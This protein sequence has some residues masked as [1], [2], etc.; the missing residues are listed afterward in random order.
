M[1]YFDSICAEAAGQHENVP[2]VALEE[3]E[4]ETSAAAAAAA[5]ESEET[6]KKSN[7][8]RPSS[9]S[10]SSGSKRPS[11]KAAR[12]AEEAKQQ[13]KEAAAA[14]AQAKAENRQHEINLTRA[15]RPEAEIL[16]KDCTINL[17][18]CDSECESFK[19][20]VIKAATSATKTSK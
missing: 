20:T 17:V 4:T 18:C 14:A 8:K 10:S 12:L 11:K 19:S 16:I 6:K 15:K 1:D 2:L 3:K 13:Q 7:N 5:A 9:S